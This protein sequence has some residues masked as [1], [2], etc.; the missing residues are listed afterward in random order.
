MGTRTALPSLILLVLALA[1]CA[2][3]P[4]PAAALANEYYNLGNEWFDLKKFDKAARAYQAALNWNPGLRIATVNLALT[5][6][7]LGDTAGALALLT[8]VTEADPENLVAAQYRAWLTAKKDGPAAAADLY[9]ALAARLP[10]DAATQF[11]AG[12]SLKAAERNDEALKALQVWKTLDGKAWT[13]LSVLAELLETASDPQ[14][15]DAWFQTA[16]AL[17]ENDAKRFAPLTR[18][19]KAL[20]STQLFGDAVQAWTSALALPSGAGQD[21]GEAQFRLGSLLLL[22]IEDYTA[23]SQALIE[24]WKSGYKDRA[25]WTAL[26]E[27][28]ALR[29]G[30]RLEA[31]LKLAGVEP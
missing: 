24:A 26:R 9:A 28:P 4:D 7:E 1:S 19:A 23:G 21:R 10:G 20:E 14:A 5:K 29:Y 15:A 13:G 3:A 30:P 12:L 27:N 22:Q 6:A 17:P 18:Q 31:D 2:T 11:N 25:A 16:S 8:P